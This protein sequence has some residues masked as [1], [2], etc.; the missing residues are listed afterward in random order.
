VSQ[1][2]V[3]PSYTDEQLVQIFE[4]M[5][6]ETG[7]TAKRGDVERLV[8]YIARR[9]GR[10][11]YGEGRDVRVAFERALSRQGARLSREGRAKDVVL[12]E[13]WFTPLTLEDLLPEQ[14]WGPERSEQVLAEV[15]KLVGQ[16]KAKKFIHDTRA[17]AAIDRLR[18]EQKLKVTPMSR[19]VA[20]VGPTGTG[21]TKIARLLGQVYACEGILCEGQLVEVTRAKVIGEY[22]GHTAIKTRK[23]LES[24]RGGVLFIDEAYALAAGGK[25]DFGKEA[26]VEI[27]K[28]MEDDRGDTVIILAG[29]EKEMEALFRMN[30]GFKSRV[31][32]RIQMESYSDEQLATIA[33]IQAEEMGF[34]LSPEVGKLVG[35]DVGR[36]RYEEG[37]A[38]GRET[39]NSV[40]DAREQQGARLMDLVKKGVTPTPAQLSELTAEDFGFPA[41][42]NR[43]G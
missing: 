32:T 17:S 36:R 37:F 11:E 31:R 15:D 12:H 4:G 42:S 16:P 28:A 14:L 20:L 21:K 18:A 9:R 10:R 34:S 3:F 30:P 13:D 33:M 1:H 22:V 8:H 35:E 43:S 27:L 41:G 24:A 5:L 7:Y 6:D 25:D 2:I 39:R 19:H 26:I 40:E 38:N 29:Y 23:L